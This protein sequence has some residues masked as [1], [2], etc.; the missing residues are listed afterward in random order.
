MSKIA[1]ILFL[2]CGIVTI[3][4]PAWSQDAPAE[5][6]TDTKTEETDIVAGTVKTV[7]L[8]NNTL[9]VADEA[10][11]SYTLTATKEETSIWKGDN[12]VELPDVKIDDS[13]ELEYYKNKDGNLVAIWIDV[14]TKE[15]AAPAEVTP[16]APVQ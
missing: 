1:L 8:A 13:I 4:M 3:T 16:P 11:K 7:D 10:G 9:T 12:T 2:V 15:A 5:A 6:P 14:L